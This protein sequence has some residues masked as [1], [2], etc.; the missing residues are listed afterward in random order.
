MISL[1]IGV[2][3]LKISSCSPPPVWAFANSPCRLNNFCHHRVNKRAI[4]F[5]CRL[6]RRKISTPFR[7][8]VFALLS[9]TIRVYRR[10]SFRSDRVRLQTGPSV[11]IDGKIASRHRSRFHGTRWT[12][13]NWSRSARTYIVHADLYRSCVMCVSHN[14]I[15]DNS[16][17]NSDT[18]NGT[19]IVRV[20]YLFWTATSFRRE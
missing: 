5:I 20:A 1:R 18:N 3:I 19:R 9:T 12:E 10:I 17:S 2:R 16:N 8:H 13:R 6:F 4:P 7:T 11:R 15:R 14:Y